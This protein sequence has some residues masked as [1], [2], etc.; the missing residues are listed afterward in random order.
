MLFS[1]PKRML[2]PLLA[3]L[4][5]NKMQ[6]LR[7]RAKAARDQIR[8]FISPTN[9]MGSSSIAGHVGKTLQAS[10]RTETLN[11]IKKQKERFPGLELRKSSPDG[12][13]TVEFAQGDKIAILHGNDPSEQSP[14]TW[15]WNSH[16]Y[17][18][19]RSTH[20]QRTAKGGKEN[21]LDE[22][23]LQRERALTSAGKNNV[24]QES[25]YVVHGL[26]P[27]GSSSLRKGGATPTDGQVVSASLV[28]HHHNA[29][30]TPTGLVYPYDPRQVK[31]AFVDD[32]SSVR[33][34][35]TGQRTLQGGQREFTG[36]NVAAEMLP[37]YA[38]A[39]QK[40]GYL[41]GPGD[42]MNELFYEIKG[43]PVGVFVD[44]R[45]LKHGW[46]REDLVDLARSKKLPVLLTGDSGLTAM[47]V[48]DFV[49]WR[50]SLANGAS[51]SN[52][53]DRIPGSFNPARPILAGGP[54]RGPVRTLM[55]HVGQ[56]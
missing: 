2:A 35:A 20:Y 30:F 6:G 4:K 26:T 41:R 42:G 19:S 51:P 31:G 36:K 13:K 49:S 11:R 44:S 56:K 28:A 18:P 34:D 3:S 10:K 29:T 24:N 21:F 45:Q 55:E 7:V 25:A 50:G 33:L 32:V 9:P 5:I 23:K 16:W 12:S 27:E 22:S 47:S 15:G 48:D 14:A 17:K 54:D 46:F 43:D 38:A 37:T 40:T 53:A 52:I 39:S 1:D 8:S